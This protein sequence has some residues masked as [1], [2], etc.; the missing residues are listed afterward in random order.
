M[1][2]SL[3]ELIFYNGEKRGSR[4]RRD[5]SKS[6][7]SYNNYS[8]RDRDRRDDR[9]DISS[10]NRAHHNFD[11]IILSSRGEAEEVLSQLVDMTLDYGQAT[12]ADLYDLVGITSEY[13]D[14]D[15][16]WENL[17]SA[18]VSRVRDGYMLNLPRTILLK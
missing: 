17:S 4:T 15:W 7:V 1:I 9:R 10:K 11:D 13:T 2:Q 16:G 8:S 14:R 18:S 3:P 6:Y 12:V 5:G